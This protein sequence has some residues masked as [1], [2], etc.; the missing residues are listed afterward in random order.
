[1][2]VIVQEFDREQKNHTC[3][4][5]FESDAF[6]DEDIFTDTGVRISSNLSA[7]SCCMVGMT[8]EWVSSAR[9][10]KIVLNSPSLSR[11]ALT[12]AT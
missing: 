2:G 9:L 5:Y 12:A 8:C 4:T 3:A 11:D 7:I 10:M 1:M 6:F